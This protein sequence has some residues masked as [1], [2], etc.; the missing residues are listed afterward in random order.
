M[1]FPDND[2]TSFPVSVKSNLLDVSKNYSKKEFLKFIYF[3]IGN[4]VI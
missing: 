1:L 2:T 3:N 4:H